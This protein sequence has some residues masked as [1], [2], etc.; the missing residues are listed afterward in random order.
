MKVIEI[1][2]LIKFFNNDNQSNYK[3]ENHRRNGLTPLFALKINKIKNELQNFYQPYE[4]TTTELLT[5]YDIKFDGSGQIDANISDEVIN[6]FNQDYIQIM[7][8]DVDLTFNTKLKIEDLEQL[9]DLDE[10][11]I[12]FF[13]PFLL[14]E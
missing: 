2:S 6:K 12:E 5:K 14:D 13:K 9:N 3:F 8:D 7:N 10:L 11:I 4:T 1:I